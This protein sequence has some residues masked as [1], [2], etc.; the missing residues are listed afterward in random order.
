MRLLLVG[1]GSVGQGFTEILRDKADILKRDHGFEAQ[2]VG[3]NTRTRGGLYRADGLDPATLLDAIQAGSLNDY[4][5]TDGLRRDLTLEAMIDVGADVL[6]D[7][8]P[9]NLRT[10]EPSLTY[11]LTALR[12]GLHVVMANKGPVAVAYDQL[13][14]AAKSAGKRVLF[15]GAV[16]AGT[17]TIRLGMEALAGCVI[18]EARGILNGTTNYMLTQMENGRDYADVL[19]EAQRLGYAE[20]DPTADVDG[21]DAAGKAIILAAALFKTK[22][23]LDD[24]DV[25]GIRALTRADIDTAQAAGERWKLIAHVTP[26]GGSVKAVRLPMT[27][28]LAGVNGTT[29][30]VTFTTDELG[31]VTLIGAGAGRRQTGFAILSDLLNLYISR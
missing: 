29:N 19:A 1:F 31:D 16:M 24:M 25:S 14:D 17:P 4:P 8:S 2:I 20:T 9:T 13:L 28:P 26:K 5:D 12:H 18:S 11:A 7:I 27:H 15:E 30:A 10:A 22:L 6:V 23:T 3:V 21:W